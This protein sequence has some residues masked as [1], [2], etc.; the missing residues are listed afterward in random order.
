[1]NKF[2]TYTDKRLV[3]LLKGES[4]K[5]FEEIYVRYWEVLYS[6]SYKRVQSREIAEELV[7]DIF[8]SLWDNRRSASIENL[9][10]YLVTAAKYKVINFFHKE[11]SR[12]AFMDSKGGMAAEV[13]NSTEEEV[14]L[15]DLNR[16]LEREVSKLPAKRQ[17]I[18]KLYRQENLPLN[19]VASRLGI[20]EKTVEN[21]LSKAFKVLRVSLKHFLSIIFTLFFFGF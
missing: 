13:D 11:M 2:K 8:T 10:A 4:V 5:A 15:N 21:Q 1:M 9:Q 19:E 7:Q 3:E 14:M 6:T 20:S 17:M 12:K 16:A 18:Y